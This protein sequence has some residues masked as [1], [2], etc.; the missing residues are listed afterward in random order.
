MMKYNDDEKP[1]SIVVCWSQRTLEQ[2]ER[3]QMDTQTD[4][5]TDR[6]TRQLP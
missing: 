2:L 1:L 4:R 6:H 3:E 5:Q